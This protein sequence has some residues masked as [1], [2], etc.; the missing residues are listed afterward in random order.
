MKTME[1][2]IKEIEGSEALRDELMAIQDR[3]ALAAFLKKNDVSG[4][5]EDFG[6]ALNAKM[7]AE[8]EISDDAA[9]AAAGGVSFVTY[10]D[11][12][13]RTHYQSDE[14][15]VMAM[16]NKFYGIKKIGI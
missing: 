15:R 6:T 8:G 13:S 4:A 2:F 9:E 10:G 5:I 11:L 16:I 12:T 1:E 7:E 14:E 3:D